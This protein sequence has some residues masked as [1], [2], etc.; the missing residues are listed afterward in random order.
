MR[1]APGEAFGWKKSQ[2]DAIKKLKKRIEIFDKC[3]E[4][5]QSKDSKFR[6]E[7]M[8]RNANVV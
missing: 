6:L 3:G 1:G 8:K 2:K 4:S 7:R 5:T